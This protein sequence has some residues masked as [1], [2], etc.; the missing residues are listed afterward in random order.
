[1]E[2]YWFTKVHLI[3]KTV[4]EVIQLSFSHCVQFFDK[5][6]HKRVKSRSSSYDCCNVSCAHFL[7]YLQL[8]LDK[9]QTKLS[10]FLSKLDTSE[11][12]LNTFQTKASVFQKRTLSSRVKNNFF[13]ELVITFIKIYKSPAPKRWTRC[14]KHDKKLSLVNVP[15]REPCRR[16]FDHIMRSADTRWTRA[17]S[18]AGFRWT[19]KYVRR[20]PLQVEL[21]NSSLVFAII[22]RCIVLKS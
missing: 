16:T 5:S 7:Y 6:V 21:G 3:L 1:M 10:T 12:R 9:F 15:K 20:Y 2:Q 22:F 8:K 19:S 17:L 13:V 18:A 11:T 14:L 4:F